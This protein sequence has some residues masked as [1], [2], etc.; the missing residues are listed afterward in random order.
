MDDSPSPA[1]PA[2]DPPAA[3]GIRARFHVLAVLLITGLTVAVFWTALENAYHLDDHYR[4]P[5]NPAIEQLHPMGRHFVDP[6]TSATLPRLVQYRPLL[7]LSMSISYA[8]A[9][10]HSVVAYHAGN[11]LL[12]LLS[13]IVF[14]GLVLS[15]LRGGSR[16]ATPADG[17]PAATPGW[18]A[19]TVAPAHHGW[20]ALAVTLLYAVHPVSGVP[21]NYICA[22]DLLLM[23]V[24]LL[25]SFWTYVG[26]TRSGG[27]WWR[28]PLILGCYALS[29]ASKTNGVA[30]PALVLAYELTL[31]QRR[32]FSLRTWLR[33]VPFAALAVG[34][35]VFTREVL[36]FSDVE[37]LGMDKTTWGDRAE[38]GRTMLKVHSFYYLRNV[39]WPFFMRPLPAVAEVQSWLDP[40][41]LFGLLVV[42]GSL[43]FAWRRRRGAAAITF[44]I[45]AYWI[46]F[47]PTSSI[48]PFRYLAVD[49]RGYPSLPYLFLAVCLVLHGRLGA[50]S[51]RLVFA[52]ALLY[53]A[54]SSLWHNT[55]WR[56]DATFWEQS[57]KYGARP[58][59]MVNY[60][61]SQFGVDDETAHRYLTEAIDLDPRNVV[62]HINLGLLE[63]RTGD[64]DTGIASLDDAVRMGDTWADAHY[65]RA[66]GMINAKRIAD[67][68][69][70]AVRAV[71]LDPRR[72]LYREYAESVV[73]SG[74][75]DARA[76]DD[77][78]QLAQFMAL[79][80]RLDATPQNEEQLVSTLYQAA[81]A[82]RGRG[83]HLAVVQHLAQL[84]SLQDAFEQSRFLEGLGLQRL[85]RNG[86]AIVSYRRAL[87]SDPDYAQT[88][89]N[90]AYALMEQGAHG[91]AVD[92]FLRTLVLQPDYDECHLHLATCLEAL[93]QSAEAA[94]HRAAYEASL[95]DG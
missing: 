47:A 36:D 82:A 49:Y 39:L 30:F 41:M 15:L 33:V 90:L 29:M 9:G 94:R 48:A 11:I 31:G 2:A 59:G 19:T 93:G 87:E 78:D 40:A 12:H 23:Q 74:I 3:P 20:L 17:R 85:G 21:V 14:Y 13:C 79:R 75:K 5:G 8:L 50:K 69:P 43:E 25:T 67:A 76:R 37:Q 84:H 51:R 73:R 95:Q 72:P 46:M 38:Y 83:D 80:V 57:V 92:H 4:V 10:G 89:F 63:I 70:S 1:L 61:R 86:D 28:W 42:A 7:P 66:K 18:A 88:Y 26:W 34:F 27:G 44:A 77:L 71:E 60:A 91:E 55:I 35:F 54:G 64:V 6:R 62:A 45:L 16:G 24:F 32:L 22:R 56:T 58:M 52:A 81:W 68:G 65:W 53:A